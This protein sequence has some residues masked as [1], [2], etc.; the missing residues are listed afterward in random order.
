MIVGED[1]RFGHRTQWGIKKLEMFARLFK[2]NLNVI[3]K[4]SFRGRIISS[5]LIRKYIREAKF[6]EANKFLGRNYILEARVIRGTGLGR[7]LGFPTANL[8]SKDFVIPKRG[9]YAVGVYVDRE[10][11]LGAAYIGFRPTVFVNRKVSF[12]VHIFNFKKN[13]LGKMI[14]IIFLGKIRMEK[15]F[16]SLDNLKNAIQKDIDFVTSRYSIPQNKIPQLIVF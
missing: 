13:I 12:E 6:K 11:H 2:F 5:S 9:V 3:K 14:M 4:I 16:L 7:Q 1:F 8:D 10:V 15:N